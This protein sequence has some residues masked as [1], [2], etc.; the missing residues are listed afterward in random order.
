MNRR[1]C[2]IAVVTLLATVTLVVGV[3]ARG[4]ET[5]DEKNAARL[6]EQAA[7]AIPRAENRDQRHVLFDAFATPV[8]NA[9]ETLIRRAEPALTLFDRA[10]EATECDWQLPKA[11]PLAASQMAAVYGIDDFVI[12]RARF[13]AARGDWAGALGDCR[14]LIVMGRRVEQVLSI[15][16]QSQ[17]GQLYNKAIITVGIIAPEAPPDDLEHLVAGL[18]RLPPPAPPTDVV[19]GEKRVFVLAHRRL[20]ED[21]KAREMLD[22]MSGVVDDTFGIKTAPF[23]VDD[24]VADPTKRE[25]TFK[26]IE[27]L[28]DEMAA[29]LR[30]PVKERTTSW[31]ALSQRAKTAHPL[32]QRAWK[33]GLMAQRVYEGQKLYREMLSSALKILQSPDINDDAAVAAL[34]VPYEFNRRPAGFRL[35]HV[36]PRNA[37]P[38]VLTIGPHDPIDWDAIEKRNAERDNDG[39]VP[40]E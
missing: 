3:I 27:A 33:V 31:D 11:K 38:Y 29:A 19:A 32:T 8:N 2:T 5:A 1:S 7:K 36:P 35:R 21:P 20:I 16:R 10:S 13:R 26:E 12:L 18:E 40:E 14:R 22:A 34:A 24:L 30:L 28:F 17:G 9:V 4:A 37:S 15:A 23:D 6:Y 39:L 25:T